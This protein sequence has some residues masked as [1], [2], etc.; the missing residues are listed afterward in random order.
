MESD[1][2]MFKDIIK[3]LLYTAMK[4]A[5]DAQEAAFGDERNMDDLL[6]GILLNDATSHVNTAYGYYIQ[7]HDFQRQEFDEFF[8]QFNVF[9]REILNNIRTKHSHQWTDIEYR[10]FAEKAQSLAGLMDMN[11]DHLYEEL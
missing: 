1:I 9:R 4:S 5:K 6:A 3:P 11:V 7:N 2:T 8:Y 10:N